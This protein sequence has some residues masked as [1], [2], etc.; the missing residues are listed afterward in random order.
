MVLLIRENKGREDCQTQNYFLESFSEKHV[1][2]LKL[3]ENCLNI[4]ELDQSNNKIIMRQARARVEKKNLV[5]F[6]ISI[7]FLLI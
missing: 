1:C 3:G 2:F 4:L 6:P 5:L 7:Y